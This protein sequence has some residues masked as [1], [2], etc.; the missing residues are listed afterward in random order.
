MLSWLGDACSVSTVEGHK[1]TTVRLGSSLIER[2]QR[3]KTM[4]DSL[5]ATLRSS[6]FSGADVTISCGSHMQ[7]PASPRAI[8]VRDDEDEID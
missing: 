6:V 5:G 3:N 4:R 1:Q 2:E 7:T 8:T